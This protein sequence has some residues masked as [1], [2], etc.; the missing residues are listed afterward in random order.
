MQ[1]PEQFDVWNQ[2]A[3]SERAA[4]AEEIAHILSEE[5]EH[6]RLYQDPARA[7]ETPR[8][9]LLETVRS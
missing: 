5:V 7:L 1:L 3:P 2:L 6:E 8:G 4:V 9:G